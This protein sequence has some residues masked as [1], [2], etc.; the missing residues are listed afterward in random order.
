MR[1]TWLAVLALAALLNACQL[2]DGPC[3][4]G[5]EAEI[6]PT[7]ANLLPEETVQI[8][9]RLFD[10]EGTLEL[11]T[12]PTWTSENTEI[13]TVDSTGLVTAGSTTGTT[14]IIMEDERAEQYA[15]IRITVS[16]VDPVP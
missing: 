6:S 4:T 8:T 12:K 5:L 7:S 3:V 1:I 10:C 16:D 11:E 9:Y 2:D 14:N 15:S 13:A